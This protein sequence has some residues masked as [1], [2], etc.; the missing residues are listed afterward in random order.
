MEKSEAIYYCIDCNRPI[1][2][3]GRCMLCNMRERK[4]VEKAERAD[5]DKILCCPKCKT[6]PMEAGVKGDRFVVRC[7][8]CGKLVWDSEMDSA[9]AAKM[10]KPGWK[11]ER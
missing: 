4:K 10:M 9:Y 2:H 11:N 5:L 1:R 6:E 8:A 7:R 3:K